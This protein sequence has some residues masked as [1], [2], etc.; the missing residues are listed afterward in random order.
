MFKLSRLFVFSSFL[1]VIYSLINTLVFSEEYPGIKKIIL[2]KFK[3][4]NGKSVDLPKD[5][6]DWIGSYRGNIG[7]DGYP[8][9]HF[10]IYRGNIG[11]D[12]NDNI[13]V[14]NHKNNEILIYNDRGRQVR[15]IKIKHE[16][17]EDSNFE[18]SCD[19]TRF[20]IFQDSKG[21]VLNH[22]GEIIKTVKGS[23]L[24]LTRKGD[25]TLIDYYGRRLYDQNLNLI[26][27]SKLIEHLRKMDGQ[28]NYYRCSWD[29]S[30]KPL[31]VYLVKYSPSGDII[32]KK[33]FS[34][35]PDIIGIDAKDNVYL[36]GEG[37]FLKLDKDGNK[38]KSLT[39][40][41]HI[42]DSVSLFSFDDKDRE[43]WELYASE[44]PLEWDKLTCKG[45]IY[46]IYSIWQLPKGALN[47]WLK[48]GE[49]FIYKF[50]MEGK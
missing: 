44:E 21:Y 9:F 43:E 19:G 24:D 28:G 34:K 4:K 14:L 29:E 12:D 7:I 37:G 31:S 47:R 22:K 2:G 25:D 15:R 8:Y 38:I 1:I 6:P 16:V 18:V 26:K 27:E 35:C 10:G 30:K 40:P 42:S 48:G 39:I 5:V 20:F 11:I 3:S 36:P 41:I 17:A 45:N 32:W 33:L 46:R 13:Y 23:Y 50:E 49:Y